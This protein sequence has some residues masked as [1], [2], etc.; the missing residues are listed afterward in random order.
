[1]GQEN[2]Q[3]KK[4]LKAGRKHTKAQVEQIV[5]E[6]IYHILYSHMTHAEFGKWI[7]KEHNISQHQYYWEKCWKAITD[8]FSHERDEMVKKHLHLLFNLHSRC[9]TAED[10]STERQVLQDIAKVMG[11]QEGQKLTVTQ[12]D[13]KVEIHLDLGDDN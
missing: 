11:I 1:M 2:Q 7:K 6:G 4:P 9:I 10:R 3:S 12:E 8:R 5:Q 13:G